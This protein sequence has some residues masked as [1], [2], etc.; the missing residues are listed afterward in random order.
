MVHIVNGGGSV[1]FVFA[2]ESSVEPEDDGI[3]AY[4]CEFRIALRKGLCLSE[5]FLTFDQMET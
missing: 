5:L 2:D 1:Q 3:K 4:G